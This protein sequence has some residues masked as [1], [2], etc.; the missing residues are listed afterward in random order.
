M[1]GTLFYIAVNL[2]R[3]RK[4][5]QDKAWHKEVNDQLREYA[6]ER[7]EIRRA[8]LSR[9]PKPAGRIVGSERRSIF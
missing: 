7:M 6:N 5:A 2:A 3:D 9:D 8:I 1:T 4:I